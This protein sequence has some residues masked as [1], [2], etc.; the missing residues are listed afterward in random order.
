MQES[1]GLFEKQQDLQAVCA[2]FLSKTSTSLTAIN[3]RIYT[4]FPRG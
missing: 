1:A 3:F 2:P 4:A